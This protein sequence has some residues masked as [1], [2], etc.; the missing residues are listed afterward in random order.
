[1][2]CN[3][4]S[5]ANPAIAR[6]A[7]RG[8]QIRNGLQSDYADVYT[9]EALSALAAM[10]CG[11]AEKDPAAKAIVLSAPISQKGGPSMASFAA[12]SCDMICSSSVGPP[13]P[14]AQPPT[15]SAARTHIL[16]ATIICFFTFLPFPFFAIATKLIS[17]HAKATNNTRKGTCF[18]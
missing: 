13:P 7:A 5:T 2:S 3:Q 15:T 8:I 6:D 17:N 14:V 9:P 11:E 1:M 4:Q 12:S 10:A 18:Q 16:I